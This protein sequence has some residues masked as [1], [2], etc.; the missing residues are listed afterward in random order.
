MQI[1]ADHQLSVLVG[2]LED[3]N[4][5]AQ[6]A[7]FLLKCVVP[8]CLWPC[9][10]PICN[11]Y[12]SSPEILRIFCLL[13]ERTPT[14]LNEHKESLWSR[15]CMWIKTKVFCIKVSP[16]EWTT[17]SQIMPSHRDNELS[18]S[19]RPYLDVAKTDVAQLRLNPMNTVLL[20]KLFSKGLRVHDYELRSKD[21]YHK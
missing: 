18:C 15:L 6:I 16:V 21:T 12:K 17:A 2:N 8:L 1:V 9:R 10:V 11:N 19:S 5:V 14:P 20:R 4:V 3:W 7:I 13:L